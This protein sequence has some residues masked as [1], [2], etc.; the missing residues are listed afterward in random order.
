MDRAASDQMWFRQEPIVGATFLL[1]DAVQVVSG[2]Y[3]GQYGSTI[4]LLALQPEPRYTI[5]LANGQDI[6]ANESELR[7]ARL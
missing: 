5:E 3:A 7:A 1:N 6:Q 2:P 4:A